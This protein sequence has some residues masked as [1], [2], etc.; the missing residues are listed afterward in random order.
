MRE[1]IL[2]LNEKGERRRKD[3]AVFLMMVDP[4]IG[5]ENLTAQAPATEAGSHNGLQEQA[6]TCQ[7]HR[8]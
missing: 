8:R 4:G 5:V 6:Q 3:A 2:S 7:A 1:G